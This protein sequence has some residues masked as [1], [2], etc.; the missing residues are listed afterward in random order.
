MNIIINREFFIHDSFEDSID[1]R[2]ERTPE[3]KSVIREKASYWTKIKGG[4]EFIYDREGMFIRCLKY[5]LT[6]VILATTYSFMF[7]GK[8]QRILPF[9]E[10]KSLILEAF[11]EN[12]F[13][14]N[15]KFFHFI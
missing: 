8:L 10:N 12:T 5:S 13:K 2:P 14:S 9:V 1:G 15:F 6:G 3:Y 11:K 7:R 4:L